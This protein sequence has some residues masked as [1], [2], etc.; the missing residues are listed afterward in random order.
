L[1][2]F[3]PGRKLLLPLRAAIL[4]PRLDLHLSEVQ[5]LG[6][7]HPLADAEILVDLREYKKIYKK[8]CNIVEGWLYEQWGTASRTLNSASS[9]S[10][11]FAL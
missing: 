10:S 4:E 9:L 2:D 11:C 6:Q 5:T 3:Q 1:R 8:N 7:L